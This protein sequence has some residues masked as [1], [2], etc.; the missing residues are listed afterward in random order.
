M[1]L[2]EREDD[3]EK[4]NYNR[5]QI[6]SNKHIIGA[7]QKDKFEFN[8]QR[9]VNNTR[10]NGALLRQQLKENPFVIDSTKI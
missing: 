2:K 7:I 9:N 8:P 5:A 4:I 3:R 10:N 1:Q 6:I